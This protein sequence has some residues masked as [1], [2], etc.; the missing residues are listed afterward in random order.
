M[1][2]VPGPLVQGASTKRRSQAAY[3]LGALAGGF[4]LSSVLLF[5][6]LAFVGAAFWVG[7]LPLTLRAVLAAVLA[8]GMVVVEVV[9]LRSGAY[10]KLTLRRQTPQALA[11]RFGSRLGPLMW[12]LDTGLAWTTIRVSTATWVVFALSLLQLV[13]WWTG[14]AYGVGFCLPLTFVTLVLPWHPREDFEEPHWVLRML[15]RIR[16]A[17]RVGCFASL[18]VMTG[19]LGGNA[20]TGG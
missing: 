3:P 16:P 5:A 15:H 13:P 9:G 1:M 4:L 7:S 17:V 18:L 12:G 8:T 11:S 6:T 19:I 10:C 14:L 2:E 20:L